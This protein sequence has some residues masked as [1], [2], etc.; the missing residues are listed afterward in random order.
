MSGFTSSAIILRRLNYSDYD[1]IVDF[2]THTR[3]RVTAIAKNAKKSR[4]RFGGVLEL[5]SEVEAVFSYP[6]TGDGL[7][8]VKEVFLTHPFAGIRSDFERTAYAAYWA[9]MIHRSSEAAVRQK[10]VFSL[11]HHVLT[12]LAEGSMAAEKLS[13]L[14]QLRLLTLIGLAPGLEC[15][16][17]CQ[18][19]LETIA[20]D[21]VVFDIAAGGVICDRC[22]QAAGRESKTQLSMGTVK[23]LMWL[24]KSKFQQAQRVQ[25]T[26]A[27]QKES[28]MLL[29]SFVLYHLS[30][31]IKSLQVLRRLRQI[32]GTKR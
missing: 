10:G 25:F 4:K 18:R 11:F 23:R 6:K 14:F 3:G 24:Q 26:Q 17:R 2:F 22:R 30:S 12:A 21:K 32:K 20:Q 13:M 19:S 7:I 27:A 31:E 5:F 16:R 8:I 28:L 15:C 1:L 29:E 9:E